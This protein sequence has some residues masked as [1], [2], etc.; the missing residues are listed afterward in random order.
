M[1][2]GQIS[3]VPPG[4]GG[5]EFNSF[6]LKW[7][8]NVD[9]WNIFVDPRDLPLRVITSALTEI[10]NR[11]GG[12]AFLLPSLTKASG[13]QVTPE[14][15]GE[16]SASFFQEGGDSG[17]FKLEAKIVLP[18][19]GEKTV[20]FCLNVARNPELNDLH[21]E[22]FR[23]LQRLRKIDPAYV[24]E[25]FCLDLATARDGERE[26]KV[27]VFSTEWLTGYT[28]VN[29]FNLAESIDGGVALDG[30]E[31]VGM[32][33]LRFNQPS[34]S[35][36]YD[37]VIKDHFLEEAIAVEM[38]RILTAYF[39]PETMEMIVDYGINSGDFVCRL[40]SDGSFS[41]KLVTCRD[42]LRHDDFP[43]APTAVR[44]FPLLEELFRH[45]E[46]SVHHQSRLDLADLMKY[47]IYTF[48]PSEVC[49]GVVKALVAKYGA[50]AGRRE[51]LEWLGTYFLIDKQLQQEHPFADKDRF[52]RQMVIRQELGEFLLELAE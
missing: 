8:G 18:G 17:I 40:E 36:Y 33:Q 24:V 6:R 39:K 1:K 30:L 48:N 9:R 46:N 28:E 19:Q 20:A 37:G 43:S 35:G 4:G 13:L 42:I 23:N 31:A 16:L 44:A 50:K 5:R 10:V 21:A 11:D 7:R 51:A 14:R 26:I 2:A 25:P 52:F 29:M 27:A 41:L 22:I 49:E 32:R 34:R 15:I 38:V 3:R 12:R 45:R 47:S